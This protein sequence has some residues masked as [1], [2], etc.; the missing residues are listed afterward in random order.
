[1]DM[2]VP[3]EHKFQLTTV[4]KDLC[5]YVGKLYTCDVRMTKN[6][7]FYEDVVP[8]KI[9]R[10]LELLNVSSVHEKNAS[11]IREFFHEFPIDTVLYL[12]E[13]CPGSM[14]MYNC[15]AD[16]YEENERVYVLQ[17]FINVHRVEERGGKDVSLTQFLK[18]YVKTHEALLKD[19]STG[20]NEA[21][22]S[23]TRAKIMAWLDEP[24][25]NPRVGGPGPHPRDFLV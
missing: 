4:F 9:D 21:A 5:Y 17:T 24:D 18:R 3:N 7:E 6:M 1:M 8:K 25:A 22:L 14:A 11:C 13:A 16:T 10:L 20:Y 19:L 12:S 15:V 2:M 23:A